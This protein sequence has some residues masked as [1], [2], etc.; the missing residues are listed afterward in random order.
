MLELNQIYNMDCLVG[1][2]EIPDKSIDN[3]QCDLPYGQTQNDWDLAI[4]LDK[5]WNEYLRIIKPD[6]AIV[7]FGQGM[8]TAELM[9]SQKEIWR[10]NLIW[11]KNR[12]TGFLNSDKMPLRNHEDIL[13]FYSELPTYNPQMVRGERNHTRGN[14]QKAKNNNY[15]DYDVTYE[16]NLKGFMKY[17]Q[18]VLYFDRVHPP[19]HPTQ[20]PLPLLE[21]LVK[22]YSNEGDIILDNCMGSGTTAEACIR[23]GRQ[24]MGFEKEKTYFDDA[25][26]RIKKAQEQGK[27]SEW[28]D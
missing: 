6:G 15:G 26:I 21:Y 28:F 11:I 8:F 16:S 24:F 19:T 22:T 5:L 14:S 4:P 3:I 9:A 7:L 12:S 23:T 27:I 2:E 25:R 13:I 1:M 10:Y 18:S 17:P 20:K